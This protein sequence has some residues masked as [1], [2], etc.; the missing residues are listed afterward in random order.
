MFANGLPSLPGRAVQEGSGPA[1]CGTMASRPTTELQNMF[2]SSK[3]CR[4]VSLTEPLALRG[5]RLVIPGGFSFA[6]LKPRARSGP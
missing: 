3:A 1:G 2:R 4:D 5:T 6:A